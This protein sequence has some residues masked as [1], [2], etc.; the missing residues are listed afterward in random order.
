MPPG[1]SQ[2]TVSPSCSGPQFSDS[3]PGIHHCLL[4][5]EGQLGSQ[6]HSLET[7]VPSSSSAQGSWAVSTTALGLSRLTCATRGAVSL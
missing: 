6:S 3:N 4:A 7:W 2:G 1:E 5:L